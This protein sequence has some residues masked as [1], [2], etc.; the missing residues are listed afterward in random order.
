MESGSNSTWETIRPQIQ[1]SIEEIAVMRRRGIKK[2]I[3]Y[4]TLFTVGLTVVSTV[5]TG[6]PLISLIVCIIC[7]YGGTW[8]YCANEITMTY[9]TKT[10]PLLV[11]TIC[12]TAFYGEKGDKDRKPEPGEPDLLEVNDEMW[13]STHIF[14]RYGTETPFM[15]HE[16]TI[17][18]YVDKTTFVFCECKFGVE[19]EANNYASDKTGKGTT[20]DTFFS[21]LAFCAD[22]NKDMSG[23]TV[24]STV[25]SPIN[26]SRADIDLTKVT[27]EDVTFSKTFTTLSS[28][29][30]EARYI[31]SPSLQERFVGLYKSISETMGETR[32]TAIFHDGQMLILIPTLQ[33]RFEAGLFAELTEEDVLKDF[34][35]I[36]QMIEI[37]EDLNLNTRI[38]TKK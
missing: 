14:A 29:E 26:R 15:T 3:K 23:C 34:I 31:F 21:G 10:V 8:W 1:E 7:S 24:L 28:D 20:R 38:W 13:Q 27:M 37:V 6:E 25:T 12:P 30:V 9:K 18:G 33:D 17:T 32:M 2:F 11:K 4:G 35:T 22:F 5:L 36:R 19:R 16:D